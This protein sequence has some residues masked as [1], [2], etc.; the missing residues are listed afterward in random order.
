V[1]CSEEAGLEIKIPAGQ[2]VANGN[3]EVSL[4]DRTFLKGT[5]DGLLLTLAPDARLLVAA[6]VSGSLP[7]SPPLPSTG[8]V[9][10]SARAK[11]GERFRFAL[12]RWTQSDTPSTARAVARP[13]ESSPQP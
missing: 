11:N 9:W 7:A 5:S 2:P 3:V 10:L 4:G 12:A 13:L 6:R 8:T 1:P